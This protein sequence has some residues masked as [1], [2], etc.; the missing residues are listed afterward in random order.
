MAPSQIEDSPVSTHF[1]PPVKSAESRFSSLPIHPKDEPFA[2]YGEFLADQH[3]HKV[4]LG[5]GVYR[6]EDGRPWPLTTVE[7][8]EARLHQ[9][10]D[11]SRHEYLTIQGDLEF[12]SLA[13]DLVF[14][15]QE[16]SKPTTQREDK[17][18]ITS[19]QTVS[20]TGANRL[21]AEFLARSL[22]PG[23]IWIPE[24]TWS[25]HHAI[26]E[27]A[28]VDIKTYPYYDFGGNCFDYE[29]TALVLGSEAK[30]GDVVI[31]HACAHNPTG[32][33]PSKEQWMKLATICQTRGVIP[34]F[35]LAY[36]GFASG[37][38][39]EDAFAIRHFLHSRPQ[40]EFCVAQ[41]FSKNF[42]LYGQR[43]G[44][45]HVVTTNAG[46]GT[47]SQAVLS[48]LNLL[49]RSEYGMAP[50]GGSDIAKAVLGSKELREKWQ[51]DLKHM[52]GRI[53][54]MRQALY[55]E[56]VRLGTPGSW[57]HILSQVSCQQQS[58]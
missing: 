46:S 13:R 42:G 56:L 31:F 43:T 18:R 5:I 34:F 41:S 49:A 16:A 8:A 32:A 20:G 33:D 11:E 25:N 51:G 47:A 21:G 4:N 15:F 2:L 12:L 58:A 55:D 19:V 37:S 10:R 14:G 36:Q 50:R 27:L 35:D 23:T 24:P 52:S 1:Y 53:Q 44:A 17:S 29:R 48:N 22:K 9:N 45:L 40:L 7:E 57:K 38:L 26:W 39:E 28:Q 30:K 54:V 3:P 6:T